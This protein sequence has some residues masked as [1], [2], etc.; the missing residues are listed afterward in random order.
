MPIFLFVV[1]VCYCTVYLLFQCSRHVPLVEQEV[2]ILQKH[3]S[4]H[5]FSSVVRVSR[6]LVF[7]VMF[8]KSLFVRVLLAIVLSVLRYTDFDYPF[9]IFKLFFIYYSLY[10]NP[11]H[12]IVFVS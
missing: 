8:G 7:C 12:F 5:P 2:S 9:G 10:R 1:F 4:S 3:P 11:V 6:S